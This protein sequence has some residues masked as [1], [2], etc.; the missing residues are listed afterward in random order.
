MRGCKIQLLL[1][2]GPSL[3]R[4]RNAIWNGVS[5]AGRWW[6]NIKCL[7]DSVVI[8]QGI[9]TSTAKEPYSFAIFQ[10]KNTEVIWWF[11]NL[12]C[13]VYYVWKSWHFSL[14]PSMYHTYI[15]NLCPPPPPYLC[16][17]GSKGWGQL[18][19]IM[20]MGPPAH[21]VLG[22]ILSHLSSNDDWSCSC[23][24]SGYKKMAILN[25]LFNEMGSM[26]LEPTYLSK[27][28]FD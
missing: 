6:P 1:K 9:R 10:M 8:S 15:F 25:N 17:P 14:M 21:S 4:Q 16:W 22:C 24:N 12:Y 19:F 2:A 28:R 5:L 13:L 18:N 20:Y 3:A 7:F 23:F 11:G 26:W 27:V